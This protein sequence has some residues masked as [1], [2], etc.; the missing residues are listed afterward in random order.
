MHSIYEWTSYY[1]LQGVK[2]L[3]TY[4]CLI[5]IIQQYAQD[6]TKTALT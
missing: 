2:L 3:K 1:M 5:I 4:L 6:S